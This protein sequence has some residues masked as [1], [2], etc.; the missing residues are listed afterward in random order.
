MTTNRVTIVS[1]FILAL[2]ILNGC[3]YYKPLVKN[4]NGAWKEGDV[5]FAPLWIGY[6]QGNLQYR[7]GFSHRHVQNWTQNLIHKYVTPTNYFLNYPDMN[8]K[9]YYYVG[10]FNPFSIWTY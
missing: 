2:L 10:A 6:R 9:G 4:N 1:Y 8:E 3:F 5:H 7:T